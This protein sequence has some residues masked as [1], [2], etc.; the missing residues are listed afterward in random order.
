MLPSTLAASIVLYN[1]T[2]YNLRGATARTRQTPRATMGLAQST[3]RAEQ[4]NRWR[5]HVLTGELEAFEAVRE[6]YP[7]LDAGDVEP[8]YPVPGTEVN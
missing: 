1:V 7:T 3:T 5:I 8:L 6:R 4:L 2:A